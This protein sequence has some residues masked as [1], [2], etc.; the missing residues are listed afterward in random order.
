MSEEKK[1]FNG[2]VSMLWDVIAERQGETFYTSKKLPFTYR[3]KGGE[4]FAD[5]RERSITRST[6]ERAYE[7]ILNDPLI[8][9]PKRLNVYGA[10]YVWAILKTVGAV[11]SSEN[12]E[13][14]KEIRGEK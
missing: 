11:P 6:F 9:G 2:D 13:E 4:L 10:P 3:I 1:V 12:S 5:R 14:E 7:K 8:K